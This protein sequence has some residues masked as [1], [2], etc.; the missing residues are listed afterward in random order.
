M[1]ARNRRIRTADFYSVTE[2]NPEALGPS[3][4]EFYNE[5]FNVLNALPTV[6]RALFTVES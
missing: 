3:F 2:F 5:V 4:S 1:S 6:H